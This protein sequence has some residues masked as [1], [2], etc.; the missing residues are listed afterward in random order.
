M[1][2]LTNQGVFKGAGGFVNTGGAISSTP[3]P[4]LKLLPL[5]FT[6]FSTN[7]GVSTLGRRLN[8]NLPSLSVTVSIRI[9][10]DFENS[11]TLAPLTGL[12]STLNTLPVTA[13][14]FSGL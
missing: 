14:S 12:F 1:S 13:N 8:T 4:T 7:T 9:D 10:G 11:I 6:A 2:I 5:L 3:M